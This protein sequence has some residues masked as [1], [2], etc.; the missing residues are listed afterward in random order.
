MAKIARMSDVAKLAGV[1]IMTVSRVLNQSAGVTDELKK[2]VSSAVEQLRYQRNDLAR[3]LR[4]QRSRQIGIMVPYLF[5]PFFAICAHEI[6]TVAKQHAYS[7]V[8]STSDEDPQTEYEEA[9]RMLRR[10]VEGLIIIPSH[11]Q[12]GDSLLLAHEFD[13]MPIVTLDR[14]IE[15]SGFDSLL[16]ENEQGAKLGTEHLISLGHKRIAYVGLK[17]ELYTMGM[18][19]RGYSQAMTNAGLKPMS[20]IVTSAREN[21]LS[22]IRRLLSLKTKPTAILCANNLTTRHVLHS[23]QELGLYPP[24]GIALVG[25]DDFDTADLLRPGVTVVRQPS[26]LLGRRAAEVLFERLS[27]VRRPKAG[28]RIVFPVEL[29]VRGSC[30]GSAGSAKS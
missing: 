11:P 8:L 18:R 30:G 29:V 15:G 16:V 26:E 21:T 22:K 14:P 6:S 13:R 9:S 25:F 27:E 7:V 4:E 23:L 10:N 17:D 24:E 12:T 2:K 20:S 5:D 19:H 3:S 1:S 28:N